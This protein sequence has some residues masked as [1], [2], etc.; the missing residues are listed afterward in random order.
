MY[1]FHHQGEKNQRD[2]NNVSSNVHSKLQMLV[3]A[4]VVPSLLTYFTLMMEAIR[5]SETPVLVQ[6]TQ[7]HN[8]E[9]SILHSHRRENIKYYIAC[10]LL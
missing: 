10:G 3:T 8:P 5:S 2:R 6:A 1:H 9:D 4:N 7:H